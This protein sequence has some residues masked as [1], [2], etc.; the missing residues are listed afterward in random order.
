[1]TKKI[2][3][4]IV[5]GGIILIPLLLFIIIKP[6]NKVAKP[7]DNI[8]F[9]GDSIT[10]SYN[11]THYFPNQSIINSGVWG[12]RTDQAYKRLDNDVIAHNPKKIFILLGINDVG[13]GRT[14]NDISKRMTEIIK[15][16]RKYCPSS[17]IYILSICPLNIS[18]FEVWYPPMDKGI[19]DTVDEL[20]CLYIELAEKQDI[21]Y[22]D[23]SS[24]LKNENNELVKEYS[25]EGLHL[26]E[27][28]YES[29]SK[30]IEKYIVS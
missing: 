8:V 1:M 25:V 24:N 9:L 30:V 26:T 23:I 5:I 17:D 12:N 2:R 16:L 7:S 20:N 19:N 15:K 18:D 3:L 29:I 14:I 22:I 10:Q 4:L 28:A 21:N 27:A 11:L 6:T 13:Y